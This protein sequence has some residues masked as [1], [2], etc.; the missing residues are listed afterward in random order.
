MVAFLWIGYPACPGAESANAELLRQT[1]GGDL[2]K[3]T[4]D[5]RERGE[6]SAE[7][8]RRHYTNL[9]RWR[10]EKSLGYRF[11]HAFEVRNTSGAYLYDLVFATDND[12]GNRIMRTC[13]APLRSA[14]SGCALKR[15]NAVGR[16]APVRTA[17]SIRRASPRWRRA[18][19]PRIRPIRHLYRSGWMTST[20]VKREQLN[21]AHPKPVELLQRASRLDV[22]MVESDAGRRLSPIVVVS[23][24]RV[25]GAR[26]AG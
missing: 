17:C 24:I 20:R 19:C 3:P 16:S 2:W 5:A 10:L 4:A 6:L 13:M 26:P 8:A 11:T 15:S 12:A 14:S 21:P 1:F 9:L 7:E 18:R 23:S 25:L 22:S